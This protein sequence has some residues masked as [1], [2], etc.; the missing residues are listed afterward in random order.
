MKFFFIFLTII[1]LSGCATSGSDNIRTHYSEMNKEIV[2]AALGG[3][4]LSTVIAL[5]IVDKL[6]TN[7]FLSE[8]IIKNEHSHLK[9]VDA[10]LSSLKDPYFKYKYENEE[11][12]IYLNV[13]GQ[14]HDFVSNL[15]FVI[16]DNLVKNLY[17]YLKD[18]PNGNLYIKD[19][20]YV[21]PWRKYREY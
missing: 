18:V 10:L 2:N 13:D 11:L 5:P 12:W 6:L 16:E 7:S 20:S 19:Q 14:K 21:D 3:P 15:Y 8:M 4:S 17:I 9:S 1:F